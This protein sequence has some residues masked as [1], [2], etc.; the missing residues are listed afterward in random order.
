[1]I[2]TTACAN[3]TVSCYETSGYSS[4]CWRRSRDSVGGRW[5]TEAQSAECITAN[6]RWDIA[7]WL[8]TLRCGLFSRYNQRAVNGLCGG[9]CD[10]ECGVSSGTGCYSANW[11]LYRLA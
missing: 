6:L 1:M 3:I 8:Y 9:E 5:T 10:V 11:E 2:I 4:D 7:C